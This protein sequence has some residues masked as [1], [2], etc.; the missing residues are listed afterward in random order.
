MGKLVVFG[1]AQLDLGKR[2][3]P[4]GPS[5]HSILKK[6]ILDIHIVVAAATRAVH[7]SKRVRAG[8]APLKNARAPPARSACEAI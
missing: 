5:P 4:A 6:L 7:A 3:R 8:V 1:T 2:T